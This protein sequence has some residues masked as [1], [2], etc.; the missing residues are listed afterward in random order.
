MRFVVIAWFVSLSMVVHGQGNLVPNGSFEEYYSC[1]WTGSQIAHAV[2]WSSPTLGSPEYF[3]TCSESDFIAPPEVIFG[4]QH[5]HSGEAYSGIYGFNRSQTDMRE[6][7]QVELTHPIEAS[8]RYL[9]TFYASIADSVIFAI[10]TLG[11][12]FSVDAVTQNDHFTIDRVPQILNTPQNALSDPNVWVM[13]TDTFSSRYGGERFLIIGNFHP[14]SLSDT[15][16]YTPGWA[17]SA[18]FAY[19]YIDDVSVIALDSIPSSIA[20]PAQLSFEAW[21]NPATE[22]LD[23]TSKTPLARLRLL[24][25]SGRVVLTA[26]IAANRHTL[27]LH[28]LPAG[29]YLLEATDMEG[30]RAVHKHI[31]SER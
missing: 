28:G 14:D 8:A 5:P 30:R 19:Y 21:P 3:H 20:E 16:Q 6:Y 4:F 29:V 1:P 15:I 26:S 2:H 17:G 13:V 9:V 7:L 10:N 27:H 24:D 11:A 12:H 25:I 23:I 31:L 18:G 22:V